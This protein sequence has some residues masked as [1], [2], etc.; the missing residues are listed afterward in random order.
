MH[1][2]DEEEEKLLKSF[3]FVSFH[4]QTHHTFK[5]NITLP[6]T[7]PNITLTLSHNPNILETDKINPID[8]FTNPALEY[9]TLKVMFQ[10]GKSFKCTFSTPFQILGK[11]GTNQKTTFILN[12]IY[13]SLWFLAIIVETNEIITNY[14]DNN[15]YISKAAMFSH[16]VAKGNKLFTYH[17]S[18]ISVSQN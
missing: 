4:L 15:M 3:H 14:D 1:K 13:N 2:R 8:H 11:Y 18:F 10:E 9:K 17:M 5:E 6:H 7:L 12:T 16:S